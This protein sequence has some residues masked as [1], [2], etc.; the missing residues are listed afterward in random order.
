L[1][2]GLPL[3]EFPLYF[4]LIHKHS[5]KDGT[6]LKYIRQPQLT[7]QIANDECCWASQTT[8]RKRAKQ[9]F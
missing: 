5:K 2:F 4:N 1:R 6:L 9:F 7:K 8:E 3:I